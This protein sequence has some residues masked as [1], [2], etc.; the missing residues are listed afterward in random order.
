MWPH[1]QQPTRLPRPWDSPGKNTG[2]GCHFLLQPWQELMWNLCLS[3]FP[4]HHPQY[5]K[6]KKGF[7]FIAKKFHQVTLCQKY[8]RV[9]YIPNT[10]TLLGFV[11]KKSWHTNERKSYVVN[12]LPIILF[13][14]QV[15]I[16]C[17]RHLYETSFKIVKIIFSLTFT[18][19]PAI[20]CCV[21]YN[22]SNSKHKQTI[23]KN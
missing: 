19:H 5:Y 16:G 7:Y 12:F 20:V 3:T 8:L 17:I 21:I 11:C 2:V 15:N 23:S 10:Y 1:R 4:R 6:K 9:S 18:T 22:S 14:Q 13:G